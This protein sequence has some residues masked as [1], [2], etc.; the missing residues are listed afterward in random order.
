MANSITAIA[1]RPIMWLDGGVGL[2]PAHLQLQMLFAIWLG[3]QNT[4]VGT[5]ANNQGPRGSTLLI[6]AEE[7]HTE[8][9][10]M[11]CSHQIVHVRESLPNAGILS[12]WPAENR[13]F[14]L[15]FPIE[16]ANE[17]GKAI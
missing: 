9:R 14:I 10:L 17:R 4:S 8:S 13:F 16:V 3:W 11:H 7:E 2:I 15:D 5:N 12:E 6:M 1:F